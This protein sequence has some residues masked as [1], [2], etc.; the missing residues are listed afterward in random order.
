MD[1]VIINSLEIVLNEKKEQIDL[2]KQK[3]FGKLYILKS[4]IEKVCD[5]ISYFKNLNLDDIK[6]AGIIDSET[7]S[8]LCLYQ[9]LQNSKI[10]S[11]NLNDN[12]IMQL[13]NQ[14][15][16][17]KQLIDIKIN[18]LL[19]NNS[20]YTILLNQIEKIDKIYHQLEQRKP[21]TEEE[22]L[23]VCDLFKDDLYK[24]KELIL[25]NT[26]L[27]EK[28]PE[29]K[30]SIVK[31]TE[32]NEEELH[33][34]LEIY[35]LDINDLSLVSK[36]KLLLYGNISNIRN[37]LDILNDNNIH[38]SF[39]ENGNKL[40]EILLLSNSSNILTIISN[41]KDDLGI[42]FNE[43]TLNELFKQY[44]TIPSIFVKGLKVYEKDR[45]NKTPKN[46]KETGETKDN[47]VFGGFNNYLLNRE[48]FIHEG[49]DMKK[50]MSSCPS[51][52]PESNRKIKNNLIKYNMYGIDKKSIYSTLSSLKAISPLEVLDQF[53]EAG[54]YDY[55]TGCLTTTL[56]GINSEELYQLINARRS[57]LNDE[58]IF[59]TYEVGNTGITRKKRRLSIL[60]QYDS[61]KLSGVEEYK[62]EKR[63]DLDE[64]LDEF[65]LISDEVLNDDLIKKMDRLFEKEENIYNINGVV[66]SRYKVLRLYTLLL[67]HNMGSLENLKYVIFKNKII[68]KDEQKM[69]NDLLNNTLVEKKT[70]TKKSRPVTEYISISNPIVGKL[71]ELLDDEFLDTQTSYIF[72]DI[73]LNRQAI[74]GKLNAIFA[75]YREGQFDVFDNLVAAIIGGENLGTI[76]ENKIKT[77]LSQKIKNK[78]NKNGFGR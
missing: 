70:E 11:M 7:F 22:F 16:E 32:L 31:I 13:R 5:E 76:K 28:I 46:S 8:M 60:E 27:Y 20:N 25:L 21:L 38:I 40:V 69:I 12:Q 75:Y 4:E 67:K 49:I 50:V 45:K 53:L 6:D 48:L 61:N 2:L 19:N 55:I 24:L 74:I 15:L 52:L 10:S 33:D 66:I 29:E 14:L 59:L 62:Q 77:I 1:N 3:L 36:K 17:C 37:I 65:V 34:I 44:L 54:F 18:D 68:S 30:E 78:I 26:S 58:Q 51:V 71:V 23:F 41:I 9:K 43:Y 42:E 56:K 64:L 47:L 72:D 39:K 63:E 57:G 73:I 35:N